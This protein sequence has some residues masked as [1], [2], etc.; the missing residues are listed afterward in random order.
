MK[1][2]TKAELE[3]QLRSARKERDAVSEAF[4]AYARCEMPLA[5]GH[6]V[7]G[8][9]GE[10]GWYSYALYRVGRAHGGIIVQEFV[11][12]GQT[13]TLT[14]QF[15]DDWS[16]WVREMPFATDLAVKLKEIESRFSSARF[17][18]YED[19]KKRAWKAAEAAPQVTFT[20][21]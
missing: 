17:F 6:A 10:H 9:N 20:E 3:E 7:H 5:T 21:G 4:Q 11:C 16:A 8:E 13:D 19:E 2:P 14:V 1:K 15:F 12:D 18:F